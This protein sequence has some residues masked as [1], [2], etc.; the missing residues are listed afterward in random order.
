ML[1]QVQRGRVALTSAQAS[2]SDTQRR[3]ADIESLLLP[4]GPGNE[5]LPLAERCAEALARPMPR[6]AEAGERAQRTALETA[7]RALERIIRDTF[8]SAT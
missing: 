1:Q 8:L 6:N 3:I 4:L 5:R 2:V 7:V